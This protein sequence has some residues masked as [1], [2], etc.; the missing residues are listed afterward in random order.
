MVTFAGFV[1][2]QWA[3]E[4]YRKKQEEKKKALTEGT[5]EESDAALEDS[6]NKV[7]ARSL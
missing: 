4:V 2:Y 3:V 1:L 6:N 7:R 5:A